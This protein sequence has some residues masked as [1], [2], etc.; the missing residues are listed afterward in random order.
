MPNYKIIVQYAGTGFSGWQIQP[1]R[2]T[3]QGEISRALS[4]ITAQR[5]RVTGSGRTDS[6]VHARGQVANFN[7][8]S[9]IAPDSMK[10]ALN[11]LLPSTIRILECQG[12]PDSFNSRFHALEKTYIY[13]LFRSPVLSP[14]LGPFCLHFPYP[15]DLERM[16]RA[17]DL[18]VGERDF[19]SFTTRSDKNNHV[20]KVLQIRVLPRGE[21]LHIKVRGRGF[22]RYMVRTIVGTL[23]E[24][25]EGKR[26]PEE[27]TGILEGK[28]RSLA[29][30]TAPPQGLCLWEVLYPDP[31]API[32]EAV[33]EGGDDE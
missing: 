32:P 31:N 19:S 24:V 13:T 18:I 3:V 30:P 28:D 33:P 9:R 5:V 21:L 6:G 11:A 7:V 1:G 22:L 14:F 12:V 8:K 4:V 16:Q 25:G 20:K 23:L 17:A 27:M 29:G 15:L 2:T 26:S 10:R